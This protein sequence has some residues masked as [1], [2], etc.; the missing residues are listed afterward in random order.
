M[1]F[2]EIAENWVEEC[3]LQ[4][5]TR[6]TER[7]GVIIFCLPDCWLEASMHADGPVAGKLE[8]GFFASCVLKQMLICIPRFQ[9]YITRSPCFKSQSNSFKAFV[10]KCWTME[11]YRTRAYKTWISSEIHFHI[12]I[13]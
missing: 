11:G 3:S 10:S 5:S 4:N 7:H 8:A 9:V 6:V 12:K 1:I 13:G 2:S